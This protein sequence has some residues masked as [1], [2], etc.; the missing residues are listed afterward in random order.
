MADRFVAL[1]SAQRVELMRRLV[2]SGQVD[3]IPEVVPP[4]DGD[5][6]VRLSP[7]QEDLWVYQSLYP[8]TA[9]LN[10]CC[11]YHFDPPAC[12]ERLETALTLVQD[13]HDVLR[14][15]ISGGP[16][17]LRVDF[18]ECGRFRLE[19]LDLRGTGIALE[20]VLAEFR[21]RPFD[22]HRDRLIRGMFVTVDDSHATLLLCLHHLI[23]DWW[24][25]D[26]LH[27][28]FAEAYLAVRDGAVPHRPPPAI[29]YRDFAAWQR[30]LEAAG[31]FEA[32]LAF[33]RRY[34]AGLPGP[35]VV[36]GS[37]P[38]SGDGTAG[39]AQIGFGIDAAT[40]D[41][42]RSLARAHGSTVY[43]VLMCAFAVFAHRLTGADDMVIGTPVANRSARGLAQVIGYVMNA[44][45][46][47]WRMDDT[48]TF[49]G[50][51][52]RFTAGFPDLL[53]NADVPV[54]RIVAATAPE[55]DPGRSPLFQWVFMYLAK[56]DSV[57]RLRA[58]AEPERVHTG[59]EH[60]VVAAVREVDDGLAGSFEVRT[61]RYDPAIVR[62]WSPHFT[63]LLDRLVDAP[64][65]PLRSREVLATA[66][67]RLL[68]GAP[69]PP[70]SGPPPP[71]LPRLVA[72][73]AT[74]R[75]DAVAVESD[76]LSLSYAELADRVARLAGTL[77][78]HGAGPERVVALALEHPADMVV[79][80]LAVQH[81]GAAYLPLDP[82]YP[83]ERL[84]FMLADG[85][86]VLVV[87]DAA[88][89]ATLPA[90]WGGG[91]GRPDPVPRLLLDASAYR[92]D[93]LAP[94]AVLPG[95]PAYVI[96][97][98]GSTGRP[99]GVVVSHAAVAALAGTLVRH[100]HLDAGSRILQF[101]SPSFDLSVAEMC[102]VFGAGGTLVVPGTRPLA[103]EPLAGVL[104]ERGI[105]FTLLP[106]SVLASVPAGDYPTLQGLAVGAEACPPELV[107]AWAAGG[108][109]V[110]NAY[111]PT[112]STVVATL[113]DAL[114]GDGTTPAIGRPV[115]GTRVYLLDQHLRPV[116]VGVAGELYL[117][118]D[119]L[120]RGYLR[121]PGLT[122]ERFVADPYG[123]AGAR[124]YRT[125]DLAR[126]RDD[127]QL[128]FVGRADDQVKIRGLR[129]ELG[130]IEAVLAGHPSVARAVV[131]VHEAQLVA[132]TV[133]SQGRS[134]DPAAL[135][136]YSAAALPAPMVPVAIV[137][138]EALP[139]TPSGK[140]DRAA[141]PPPAG[142][143]VAPER[144]PASAREQALCGL[145]ADVLGIPTP[146]PQQD[147]FRLGGDSIG[148]ILLASRASR[149]GFAFSPRD[150]FTARTPADLAL[151]NRVAGGPTSEPDTGG[152]R[153]PLTPVMHWWRELR[154]DPAAFT[155]S[156]LFGTPAG[157]DA[158]QVAAAVSTLRL[159]HGALRLRQP[160]GAGGE[161]EIIPADQLPA[162]PVRRLAAAGMDGDA[163]VSA[164]RQEAARVRLAPASGDVLRAVW[165]DA[166]PGRD[167]RLLLAVHHLAV[168]AVSWGV[169]GPQLSDLLRG[170]PGRDPTSGSPGTSFR[171]W[172]LL[173]SAEAAR[174]QRAVEAPRW[175]RALAGPDA[176]LRPE[177]GAAGSPGGMRDRRR[178]S[179]T[180][181]L[182]ASVTGPVLARVP[183]AFRCRPDAVLLTAL[184]AAAVRWRG[185]GTGLLV[186][187]EG[188]GREP[189]SAT[190]DVSST[191]GWFTTQYPV[192]LD[193]GDA[194][195]EQYWAGGPAV[196]AALTSV[197]EQLR[198]VP[199][200][201]LGWG[202]L[203]YLNPDTAGRLAALPVPDI[204]FNYLGRAT[205]GDL[206]GTEL[207]GT[208]AAGL[209]L[210]HLVE[211]D[212]AAD[213]RTDGPH[214]V[215]TWSY[216]AG[217]VSDADIGRLA[218]W[219]H[220]A[221]RMLAEHAGQ[222]GAVGYSAADFPLVDLTQE[223]LAMLEADL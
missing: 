26:V 153:F 5:G 118:G 108:R 30:E 39:I 144:S 214:L 148:A 48:E 65:A 175:E 31:V 149:A 84:R 34:L 4:H 165:Y 3:A 100:F 136:R 161:L 114:A 187:L 163:I 86:P 184:M 174:P 223:Q 122:A 112:E 101:S 54:G 98:S 79:A 207:L 85:A 135:R 35:L 96:Y 206:T 107:S 181:E 40:A 59:G 194:A 217:M 166:G 42:V 215:A 216:P 115:P 53:A 51:L 2:D 94:P 180:V 134:A 159:R 87:T 130:E 97:T 45:P 209:P 121:R 219:W 131:T 162:T 125:G 11:A 105:T 25:F 154:A 75:P 62:P 13:R 89:A 141:L 92:A 182:P 61:D 33:W 95:H 178:A 9:A 210:A 27:G 57:A 23:T 106:P 199:S 43:G 20:R 38:A 69:M 168:D 15:R 104:Q 133:A 80:A 77:A 6:P 83:A 201:G 24:S 36:P 200:R 71:A 196:S 66:E 47:R 56:Q 81:T 221:L 145:V 113:S 191:V 52:R 157:I 212:V 28:D 91:H 220:D 119:A 60:D 17:E 120:A 176:R 50:I 90:A 139:L 179:H 156:A 72:S 208:T 12:P 129:I 46:T 109:R 213:Q 117:A 78:G 202:L 169:L 205:G 21:S 58:F 16:G 64:D 155:M 183:A 177:R 88:T 32:R 49:A 103:G 7:A 150:V 63:A 185:T 170:E 152:G 137:P 128:D 76:R 211:L 195:A 37:R 172:A 123:P 167:G 143:P 204:R 73:H 29:Q 74:G 111:G 67:R 126:W 116:P 186:Q 160:A 110:V 19:R 171:R 82:D 41:A 68:S 140:L 44:V 22:L 198:A 173:L 188:H 218:Q 138:L 142:P 93:P 197:K 222:E 8:G 146:G 164:A 18:P 14:T 151:L 203:R 99:K 1:T 70:V 158:D 132:Y 193:P 192:R 102:M 55:R 124:M 190:V 189:W 147:F 10:L 127:G